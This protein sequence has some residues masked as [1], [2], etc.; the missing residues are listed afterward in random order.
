MPPY[1]IRIESYFSR[2]IECE[3]RV[4]ISG[5]GHNVCLH[6]SVKNTSYFQQFLHSITICLVQLL[7]VQLD[8][9]FCYLNKQTII[10]INPLPYLFSFHFY[11][12]IDRC[13]KTNHKLCH[14]FDKYHSILFGI[15]VHGYFCIRLVPASS[16]Q[17]FASIPYSIH[18]TNNSTHVIY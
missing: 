7:S 11:Y 2:S 5:A 15:N 16:K 10:C 8:V 9:S 1:K 18:H 14:R 4:V 6:R 17:H 13:S 3:R 12:E